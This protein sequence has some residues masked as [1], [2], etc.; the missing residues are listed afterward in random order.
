MTGSSLYVGR[1][2]HQRHKPR[3]H[4][5]RYRCHWM[6]LDLDDLPALSRR[7]KLFSNNHW[8]IFSL[9]D[10]DYGDLSGRNINDYVQ[11]QLQAAGLPEAG[12]VVRL[13]TM[14]RLSG[15]RRPVSQISSRLR[16]HSRSSRRED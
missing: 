8:N 3:R 1:V 11:E 10:R 14:P 7:L 16:P 4:G 2:T 5:L 9:Y 12:S 13:L 15:L 6:L